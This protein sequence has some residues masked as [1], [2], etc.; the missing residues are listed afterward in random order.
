MNTATFIKC[1][2]TVCDGPIEFEAD[3]DDETVPCPHCGSETRLYIPGTLPPAPPVSSL[4]LC[5]DCRREISIHAESCPHCGAMRVTRVTHGVFYY[6]FM[7]LLSLFV[8]G[9]L[10]TVGL[11]ILGGIFASH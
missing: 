10:A 11:G 6:V 9:I 4:V 3:H 7:T 2:C 5:P 1:H 8:I